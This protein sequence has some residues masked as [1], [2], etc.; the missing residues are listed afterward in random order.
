MRGLGGHSREQMARE[1]CSRFGWK[2]GHGELAVGSCRLLLLRLERKGLIELPAA[3][4]PSSP[5]R[6][7][8][9]EVPSERALVEAAGEECGA[10]DGPL[11]VRPIVPEEQAG[12][13]WHLDRYHYLGSGRL[14]GESLRYAAFLGGKMA[15][16]LG[17][18]A[19]AL[20]NPPRDEYLGWDE[21]TKV[22]RLPLVVCNVRFLVLPWGR[23]PNLASRV[24]AANLRRL[25]QDWERVFGHTILLAETFVDSSRFLGT[26]Y[27]ASNWIELGQTHGFRR[28]GASYQSHGCPKAVFVYPLIQRARERLT[29]A[30]ALSAPARDWETKMCKIEVQKLPL[31]GRGG[32]VEVLRCMPDPRHRRGRRHRMVSIMAIAACATLAGAQSLIGIAEWAQT[33]STATLRRLGCH[34]GKAPSEPTIRRILTKVDVVE[35]DRRVGGWMARH[36]VLRGEGLALDGKT[37]RGSSDGEG[38]PVHLVSAVLHREGTVIAQHRVPDKT[39]EIKSVE[40][41]LE[42]L[43]ITGAVVTGDAMFTQKQIATHLVED[44]QADYLFTVKDN[45]PTLRQDIEDLHLEAFPPTARDAG[46]GAR[47]HR[48][49]SNLDERR[50]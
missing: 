20:H 8:T 45:Q 31:D 29:A 14:V 33:Q 36:G 48:T 5:T 44:K 50:A 21:T 27:R 17:W 16:L 13:R 30:E 7:G 34:D 1:V 4:R 41:L 3:L 24:L 2:D 18:A 15:A 26:C 11:L 6:S 49:A 23:Y 25:R 37:L 42:S 12:W 39:N 9:P 32:L 10:L 46:Q 40:P 22:R 47:S 43:D 38:K 35:L 19:A 28:V